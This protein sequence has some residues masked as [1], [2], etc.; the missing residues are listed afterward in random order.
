[1]KVKLTLSFMSE[2]GQIHH[3]SLTQQIFAEPEKWEFDGTIDRNKRVK[4]GNY[5]R[6]NNNKS[7]LDSNASHVP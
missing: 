3:L 6:G 5:F 7:Y 1:M 4:S 2:D